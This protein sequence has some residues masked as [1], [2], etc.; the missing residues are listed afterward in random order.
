[1]KTKCALLGFLQSIMMMSRCSSCTTSQ[2][3]AAFSLPPS[4][5]EVFRSGVHP[6]HDFSTKWLEAVQVAL[7]RWWSLKRITG[8]P[9]PFGL[10]ISLPARQWSVVKLLLHWV[11]DGT[12]FKFV[13]AAE[14]G[15][16]SVIQEGYEDC[17]YVLFMVAETA[18][19]FVCSLAG[20]RQEVRVLCCDCLQ[21]RCDQRDCAVAVTA[22]FVPVRIGAASPMTPSGRLLDP[23]PY[24]VMSQCWLYELLLDLV[25]PWH[26]VAASWMVCLLAIFASGRSTSSNVP[27]DNRGMKVMVFPTDTP[28]C[29]ESAFGWSRHDQGVADLK[30]MFYPFLEVMAKAFT[31]C[32]CWQGGIRFWQ[33]QLE[34]LM[35]LARLEEMRVA[36]FLRKSKCSA[37]AYSQPDLKLDWR[38]GALVHFLKEMML[39]PLSHEFGWEADCWPLHFV[40]AASG[41]DAPYGEVLPPQACTEGLFWCTGRGQGPLHSLSGCGPYFRPDA[42][43]VQHVPAD[44]W[45]P[46]NNDSF[47]GSTRERMWRRASATDE[48]STSRVESGMRFPP[49]PD[50]HSQSAGV[51]SCKETF[52]GEGNLSAEVA[53]QVRAFL[54]PQLFLAKGGDSEGACTQGPGPFSRWPIYDGSS[55]WSTMVDATL[56][57]LS[58]SFCHLTAFLLSLSC[59]CG[60]AERLDVAGCSMTGSLRVGEALHPGPRTRRAP[61]R[62][63]ALSDVQLLTPQTLALEARQLDTFKRWCLNFMP[64]VDMEALFAT[65]PQFLPWALRSFSEA[66][67]KNGGA[68]SN[69]RHLVLAAQR[70]VPSSRVYMMPAW[71]MDEKW[72]MLTPVNHR[73]PIPETLVMAMCALAWHLKWY[74]WVGATVLAFYGAGRLGEILRCSREDLVLPSDVLEPIG[75]PVFLRLRSFK[76]QTRQ[77]AKVQHMKVVDATASRILTVIFRKLPLD[78]PLFGA[79]PYQYRKRWDLLLE[80]L[81]IEKSFHLTPGGLRGGAKA[82]ADL[83]WLLRLRSPAGSRRP[84]LIGKTPSESQKLHSDL[85]CYVCIFGRW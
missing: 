60:S 41:A 51:G 43:E 48:T 22:A 77:P 84:Q 47:Q 14:L 8:V 37:Y 34:S 73:T 67:F 56:Q 76:S 23:K 68:L 81:G 52:A 78:A 64:G 49:R 5:G 45:G 4:F 1:M 59:F 72:E 33:L 20:L 57:R 46:H 7:L 15:H 54:W 62:L 61:V 70:W 38:N 26:G 2:S 79:S 9:P 30:D 74:G 39:T 25:T 6:V 24:P 80:K 21:R 16:V 63:G 50:Q 82:I 66:M 53:E 69:Y 18:H 71:E 13:E 32:P 12:T 40:I 28:V 42:T 58:V 29:R 65:V 55:P 44:L 31:F 83:L 85:C 75:A 10:G 19:V 17:L 3:G 27:G 35:K 36:N 11:V